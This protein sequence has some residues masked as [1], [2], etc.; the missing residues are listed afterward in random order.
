[1]HL[2]LYSN[3]GEFSF[4]RDLVGNDTIPLYTIL[5]HT[6]EVDAK[7]VIFEDITKGTSKD[8]SSSKKI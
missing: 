7:E 3:D 8:K 2:L 5:S 1:M 4:N 6:W